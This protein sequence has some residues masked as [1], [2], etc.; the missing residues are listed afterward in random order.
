[1]ARVPHRYANLGRAQVAQVEAAEAGGGVALKVGGP[2]APLEGEE[3][4]ES[5]VESLL[6]ALRQSHSHP[7][8]IRL[9]ESSRLLQLQ[10]TI[11][12]HRGT[13]LCTAT[14]TSPIP[15]SLSLSPNLDAAFKLHAEIDK[16]T[17][18]T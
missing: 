10:H 7:N 15:I 13:C 1:M 9:R 5:A 14:L 8:S 2:L 12:G 11:R 16:S 4:M 3:Q 17:L 18:L 6:G